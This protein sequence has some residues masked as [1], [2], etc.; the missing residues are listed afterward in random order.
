MK[1]MDE[2]MKKQFDEW[3]EVSDLIQRAQ[4][5][6][7]DYQER[8]HGW[9]SPVGLSMGFAFLGLGFLFIGLA[10]SAIN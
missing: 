5:K 2:K 6:N 9:R 4:R 1:I 7:F 3:I 8:W 10:V